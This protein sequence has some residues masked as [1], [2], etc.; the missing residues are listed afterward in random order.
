MLTDP[1][2]QVRLRDIVPCFN[3]LM[4]SFIATCSR[5]GTPNVA[6]LS[7]VYLVDDRHV[8]LSCQF[9]NKTRRNVAENPLASVTVTDPVSLQ[10][11]ELRVRY[12]HSETNG[13]LF[14]EMET[15]IEAIA[16][17]T[18][19]RGV[20]RLIAADVYEVLGAR[21]VEG[22][23]CEPKEP[24]APAL[25]PSPPSF[26]SELTVL[27]QLTQRLMVP[28]DLDGLL[29]AL[30]EALRSALGFEHLM[31]LLLDEKGDRLFTV[32]SLG[33]EGEGVG[34]EV[35]M[36]QGLIGIAAER[37]RTLKLADLDSD[38]RYGRAIRRSV[39]MAGEGGERLHPEIPLPGLKD[40]QSHMAIPLVAGDRLIGVLAIESRSSRDFDDWHAAFL[41]IVGSVVATAIENV[42]LRSDGDATSPPP[43]DTAR[44]VEAAQVRAPSTP[45]VLSFCLY[46]NDD[47]VFVDG[48]YL[49]RNVPGKILWKILKCYAEG[50]R[51]EFTNRELRLDPAL[52]LPAVKDNLESRLIL[53]R[54]RLEQ[55][56]PDVR[57]L[58]QRR[59]EFRLEV[60]QRIVLVEKDSA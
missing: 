6:Y 15:R 4:P 17:Q 29:A 11:Y 12:R 1:H 13:P 38:L 59:G 2:W 33:Y 58:P 22:M 54:R 20:F 44:S 46:R 30:L 5:D 16:S 57:L 28:R 51:V 52:G 24:D 8:A 48:K 41:D 45:R 14:D 40:A 53:L 32:A 3:G 47:C 39:M 42:S 55:K 37:K 50:G 43:R 19:M 27:R 18:G 31:V 35:A 21:H 10:H 34:A 56:C 60:E 36:G 7:Q 26:R 23:L 25:E 49:I 9:F